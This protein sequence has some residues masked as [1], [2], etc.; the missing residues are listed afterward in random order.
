MT[1]TSF[2]VDTGH[3]LIEGWECGD[4]PPALFLHGGPGLNEYG[5]LLTAEVGGWR[6]VSFQQRGV[7]PSTSGGPFT[8]EQHTADAAA[9]LDDRGVLRAVV[10]GHSFGGYLALHF[11]VRYP[12]RVVGLVLIDSLG[13]VG[14]GGVA[15]LARELSA[16]LQPE[17][18]DRIRQLDEAMGDQPTDEL[19]SQQQ[20]LLWPSYFADPAS[21]PPVDLRVSVA[22]HLGARASI[23]EHQSSGFTDALAALTMPVVSVL[24]ERSPMPLSQGKQTAALIPGAEVRVIPDAGHLPWCERPGC[25]AAALASVWTRAGE[26]DSRVS[27]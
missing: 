8:M 11:A 1:G 15:E 16:R 9:V 19:V 25:V 24:G 2:T 10:V 20:C 17:A 3:G 22:A 21:A 5:E 12:E 4:G 23:A 14:D 7:S 13:V 26:S 18:R 27:P 6:F